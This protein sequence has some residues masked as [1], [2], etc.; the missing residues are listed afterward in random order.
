MTFLLSKI[1][2][3]S[4]TSQVKIICKRQL[5]EELIILIYIYILISVNSQDDVILDIC[6]K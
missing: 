4:F 1:S 3:K 6:V 5:E 2:D